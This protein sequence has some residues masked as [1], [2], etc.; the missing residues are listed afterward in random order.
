MERR[1][2]SIAHVRPLDDDLDAAGSNGPMVQC[3]WLA[4]AGVDGPREG[5]LLS[6]SRSSPPAYWPATV[7]QE[8]FFV[9]DASAGV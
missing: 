7:I 1:E 9:G 5:K 3:S 6:D 8:I 4:A 2:E